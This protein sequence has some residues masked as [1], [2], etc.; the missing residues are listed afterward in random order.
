VQ[1][2]EVE[3]QRGQDGRRGYDRSN[4]PQDVGQGG[5]GLVQR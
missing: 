3:Q 5:D 4:D 1:P 2:T